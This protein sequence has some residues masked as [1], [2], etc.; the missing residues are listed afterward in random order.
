M[1]RNALSYITRKRLKS[2]VIFAVILVMA[3]LSLV[4]L[5]IK[6]ATTEASKETF[7]GITNSFSIQINRRVNQGTARGAGNVKGQDIKKISSSKEIESYI[8]RINAVGDLV[9]HD[10]IETEETKRNQSVERAKTFGRAVMLTGVN[11]SSKEDK[12]VSGSFKLVEGRHLKTGDKDKV[13]LHKDLAEKNKLKIGDK[14][15]LKSNLYDADNEK[16][17]NETVEAE[18]VGLFEGKNKANV[19]YSQELYENN[20]VSDLH[21]AAKLYGNTEDTATYQDATFFVNG[22]KD[23]DSVI[24]KM[25]KL[26]IDWQSY[27]LI[28]SS[29]NYPALQQSISGIYKVANTLLI[30]S[31]VFA[32]LVLSLLLLLWINARKKEIG[33]MLALGITKVHI[34]GQFIMEVLTI[35]VFAFIGSYFLANHTGK[36]IANSILNS[37]TSDIAKKTASEATS[38]N[39][40]GGAEV[41][42]FNKYLTS[43]DIHIRSIDM[44]YVIIAGIIIMLIALLLSSQKMLRKHPKELLTDIE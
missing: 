29:N 19:S 27:D 23:I 21:T 41:D 39:L 33:I 12:F 31:L 24:E 14:I 36:T 42:G 40:G 15:K 5:S 1:F 11:D 35:G 38:A 43:L 10:I 6:N 30:G 18:I 37:V 4:S 22:D 8:K 17:A 25:K 2:L 13:I 7:K 16:Q 9:D 3:T 26:D 44:I 28:K 34:L 20:I 32:G